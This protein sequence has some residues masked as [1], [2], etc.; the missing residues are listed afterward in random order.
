LNSRLKRRLPYRKRRSKHGG[1]RKRRPV[2]RSED[3]S[4]R[5]QIR[6]QTGRRPRPT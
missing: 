4:S 6:N 2:R 3:E 1:G 5:N